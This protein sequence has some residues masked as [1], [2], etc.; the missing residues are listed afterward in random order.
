MRSLLEKI[1]ENVIVEKLGA[2]PYQEI[3]DKIGRF[4]EAKESTVNLNMVN[5]TAHKKI[6]RPLKFCHETGKKKLKNI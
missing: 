5:W 1:K 3:S 4:L 2:S 6:L